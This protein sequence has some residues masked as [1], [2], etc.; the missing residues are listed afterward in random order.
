MIKYMACRNYRKNGAALLVVLF[1]IMAITILSLG[2]L[3]QSDVELACGKNMYMRTGMDYIAESGLEHAKGFILNPQDVSTSWSGCTGQ[4]LVAGSDYYDIKVIR[5]TSGPNDYCNYIIDC[6]AYRLINSERTGFS[7]LKARLRLDPCVGLWSNTSTVFWQGITINA[8]V[9]CN[10][11][12]KGS[13]VI[14]GDVFASSFT[15]SKTGRQ[16]TTSDLSLAW[17]GITIADFVSNYSV[18]TIS[19]SITGT[20]NGNYRCTSNLE[21][22]GTVQ[23]NGMLLVEGNLTVSG[24]SNIVAGKNQPAIY[25]TGDL[26][27][28]N[29]AR[30]T[31]E[32]LAA[33]NGRVLVNGNSN[34][35]TLGG[36]F[37]N[38]GLFET[39]A[40][41]S[42]SKAYAV[43][44]G[45]PQWSTGRIN[46]AAIFDGV[47]DYAEVDN[48]SAFDISNTITVAAWI[49]VG[50][51]DKGFQAII[52]KG[53]NAWRLQRWS[54]TNHIEFACTGLSHNTYGNIESN[55]SVNDGQWHHVAGV[56]DGSKIYIYIDGVL[57]VSANTSGLINQNNYKVRIGENAQVTGR[58]WNGWIDDVQIYNRSL[59]VNDIAIVKNGVTTTGLIGRWQLDESNPAVT[60]TAEPAKTAIVYWNAGAKKRWGQASGAFYKSIESNL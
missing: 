13:D 18:Q 45:I 16:Y 2:F 11:A 43:L 24:T 47:D 30:L 21:L 9:F 57:D 6:N 54:S 37:T 26:L 20:Y 59:D 50:S 1:V 32:G 42:V 35:N 48:E 31:I 8:D 51:F 46:G 22:A 53:D 12:L 29:G 44:R 19:G 40:D 15:G 39:T 55:R 36:L 4:Q 52:T 41:S 38:G 25:V 10:G 7:S 14:N 5:D 49:K 17:P 56:Y 23:I 58:Y 34:V 3:S 60:I 33:V 28:Q 27:I